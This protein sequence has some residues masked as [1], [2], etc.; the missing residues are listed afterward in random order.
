[1]TRI[2]HGGPPSG[3]ATRFGSGERLPGSG[4]P[5]P[6]SGVAGTTSA[7]STFSPGAKSRAAPALAA[8]RTRHEIA[9]GRASRRR[10]RDPRRGA[11]ED[12][13]RCACAIR[14]R[15]TDTGGHGASTSGRA[16][17]RR[18][19]MSFRGVMWAPFLSGTSA[20]AAHPR[21]AARSSRWPCAGADAL[22]ATA[23]RRWPGSIRQRPRS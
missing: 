22:G 4:W 14:A 19:S 18:D 3:S 15:R 10:A 23:P 17:R 9:T 7:G 12:G 6:A 13:S 1:M 21:H 11:A 2:P 20:R 8:A 5:N 16:A